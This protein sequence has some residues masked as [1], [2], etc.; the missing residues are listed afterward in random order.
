MPCRKAHSSAGLFAGAGYSAFQA[1]EQGPLGL[2]AETV[3]GALGG[4]LG[5]QLPDVLEPA[6]HSWHR[7]IAHSG[8]TGVAIVTTAQSTLTAWQNHCRKQADAYRKRRDSI[9][10]VPHPS[11]PNLFAPASGQGWEHFI[12]TMQEFFWRAAAGFANGVA[13]GYISHLA[14]DAVTPRSI[15]L[16]TSGF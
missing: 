10:M 8:A 5:G 3:G 2:C 6:I 9:T 16:L 15:P 11:Q 13:A 7:S 14:L 12:L 1:K 4:Y